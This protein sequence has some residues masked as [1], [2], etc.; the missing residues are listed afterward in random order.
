MLLAPEQVRSST[1]FRGVALILSCQT[2][3]YRVQPL[4]ARS[5]QMKLGKIEVEG[6]VAEGV[7]VEEVERSGVKGVEGHMLEDIIRE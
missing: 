1:D 6:V 4:E 7:M 3:L 5:L 2:I